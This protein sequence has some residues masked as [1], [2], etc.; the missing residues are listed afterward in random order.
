MMA[1]FR[2]DLPARAVLE[3]WN[4]LV[5]RVQEVPPAIFLVKVPLTFKLEP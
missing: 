2:A 5:P 3:Q 1:Y 4:A